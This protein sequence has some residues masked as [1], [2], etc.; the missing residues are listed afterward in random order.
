MLRNYRKLMPRKYN[1]PGGFQF[2]RGT[3]PITKET[4]E[5]ISLS[6]VVVVSEGTAMDL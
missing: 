2:P 5:K 1:K 3:T 4:E 6:S